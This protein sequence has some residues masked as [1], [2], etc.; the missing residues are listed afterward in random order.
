MSL[1]LRYSHD[2]KEMLYFD[3]LKHLE[4]FL[5]KSYDKFRYQIK[6][7]NGHEIKLIKI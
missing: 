3:P 5:I 7:L 2:K 1:F 4:K 6:L